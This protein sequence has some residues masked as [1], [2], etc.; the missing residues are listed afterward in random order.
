MATVTVL[1]SAPVTGISEANALNNTG[2][3]V[4]R[5]DTVFPFLW[6]PTQPNGTVGTATRLPTLPTGGAP[7]EATAMSINNNGIVVGFSEGLDAQGNAVTRAVSWAGGAIQDLGTLIPDPANPG[8]FLGNSRAIDVNDSGQIVGRSDTIFTSEHAFLFDPAVGIMRDL[9]SLIPISMVPATPD[10]SRATSINNLGDIVG[11]SA[12]LDRNGNIVERA[13]LLAAGALSM[14]DLGTLIVDPNNPGGFLDNSGAFGIN[15][16]RRIIGTSD[17]GTSASGSLLTGAVE[18]GNGFT[19]IGLL[20]MH[21]DGFD[22]GPADHVVGSFNVPSEGFVFHATTGMVSLTGLAAT[23]GMT[24]TGGT[25]VNSSG[26]ITAIADAG[27]SSV[28]VLITP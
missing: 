15:D 8:S 5:D 13:F 12:A 16:T 18:F 25:G 1:A 17:A 7:G 2:D 22:L 23:S 24:I 28:G 9:G 3:V 21:S 4:G 20:P 19:P 27:G 6:Q 14:I 11:V 26:Q 10:P